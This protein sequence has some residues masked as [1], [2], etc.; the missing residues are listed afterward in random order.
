MNK[1]CQKERNAITVLWN[2][3]ID[4]KDINIK[5][6]EKNSSFEVLREQRDRGGDGNYC[7]RCSLTVYYIKEGGG[8]TKQPTS[9]ASLLSTY[10]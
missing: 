4:I 1:K 10:P 3:A 7:R 9:L 5:C 2:G 8:S 6:M